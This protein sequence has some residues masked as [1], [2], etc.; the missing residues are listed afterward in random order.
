MYHTYEEAALFEHRFWL[1]ILGDHSRFIFDSLSPREAEEVQVAANFI[2]VFDS[3]LAHARQPLNRTQIMTLNQQILPYVQQLRQFKL[4]LIQLHLVGKIIIG[5]PP[6]FI[7]HMVNEL[8]E[9]L[10]LLGHLQAGQIPPAHHPLHHHLLWLMDGYGHAVAIGSELDAVEKRLIDQSRTF[11]THFEDYY[12][13][14]VEL[15]GY[16]RTNLSDFPALRRFNHQAEAEMLFFMDF[17]TELKEMRLDN[18]V[19]GT[20]A[21]LLPDHMFREECYY[22]TKLAMVSTVPRPNCD[23]TKPRVEP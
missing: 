3:L 10:R 20:L 4:N 5:L 2:Q 23:P 17:L 8:D 15:T 6:T 18:S 21:P 1:Q 12:R 14:A 22:L 7:N 13:K 19:L 11:A 9:Y 16:L